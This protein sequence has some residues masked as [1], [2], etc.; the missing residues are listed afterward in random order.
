MVGLLNTHIETQC[1]FLFKWNLRYIL[2]SIHTIYQGCTNMNILPYTDMQYFYNPIL[3]TQCQYDTKTDTDIQI[4]D[5]P[6]I[7]TTFKVRMQKL[8]LK[9]VIHSFNY[10][11]FQL[12]YI[13]IMDTNHFILNQTKSNHTGIVI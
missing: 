4:S 9:D 3:D 13:P 7:E 11:T 8:K 5:I 10:G 1:M 2:C 6:Y 12:W